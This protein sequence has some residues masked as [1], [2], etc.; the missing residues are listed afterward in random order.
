MSLFVV[1]DS[2]SFDKVVQY[3]IIIKTGPDDGVAKQGIKLSSSF[4][5]ISF[6]FSLKKKKKRKIGQT[7]KGGM[8]LN[9]ESHE[10]VWSWG[11]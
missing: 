4:R 5:G 9:H 7:Q 6:F 10:R 2:N 1:G 8:F 3:G 11:R